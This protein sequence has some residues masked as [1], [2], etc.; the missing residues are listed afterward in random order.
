M[1]T[2]KANKANVGIVCKTLAIPIITFATLGNCDNKIPKGTATK[3]PKA[4]EISDKKICSPIATRSVWP[5]SAKNSIMITHSILP[6]V[7]LLG[8]Y[9]DPKSDYKLNLSELFL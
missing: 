7:S 9:L 5:F 6:L 3:I 2:I 8:Q 4:K 1:G